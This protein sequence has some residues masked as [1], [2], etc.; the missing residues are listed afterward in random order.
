MMN[1]ASWP[2]RLVV[3][4]WI[5]LN[6]EDQMI[7]D[8]SKVNHREPVSKSRQPSVTEHTVSD[9]AVEGENPPITSSEVSADVSEVS[10]NPAAVM[11]K[12][13]GAAAAVS[14]DSVSGGCSGEVVGES[15]ENI[16]L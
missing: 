4:P 15:S 2:R 9:V 12:A 11:Y 1:P 14:T 16:G 5:Y 6:S 7:S 13:E 8:P 3:K 10:S